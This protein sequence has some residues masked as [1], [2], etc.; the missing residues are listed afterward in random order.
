MAR[1]HRSGAHRSH[2]HRS[3]PRFRFPG[4]LGWLLAFALLLSVAPQIENIEN[5]D[6]PPQLQLQRR[7]PSSWQMGQPLS[8]ANSINPRPLPEMRAYALELVNRDRKVNGLLPLVEDPL[9]HLAAQKHAEDML[10]RQFFAHVNLDGVTPSGRFRAVGGQMGAAENIYRQ[11]GGSA[12]VSYSLAERV[13]KG[14]MESDGHRA[15]LLSP[16]YRAFGY[17]V[18]TSPAGDAIY[19]VQMFRPPTPVELLQGIS[20]WAVDQLPMERFNQKEQ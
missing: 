20:R 12:A 17:G 15:N 19:A 3:R 10:E 1:P 14:W 9:L 8:G 2:S 16:G 13:Q 5:L 11:T 7:D 18:A 4:R 6:L